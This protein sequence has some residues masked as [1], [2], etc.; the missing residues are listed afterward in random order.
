MLGAFKGICFS[1]S[2]QFPTSPPQQQLT[3]VCMCGSVVE[4][5]H[6]MSLALAKT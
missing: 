2:V 3:I 1:R 6:V 5:W 4:A